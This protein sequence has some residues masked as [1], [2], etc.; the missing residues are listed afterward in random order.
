[1]LQI[2]EQKTACF[3][4]RNEHGIGLHT[5]AADQEYKVRLQTYHFIMLNQL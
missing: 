1:M 4:T 3:G 2:E 5:A